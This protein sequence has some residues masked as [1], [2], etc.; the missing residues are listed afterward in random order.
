M[1]ETPQH[2]STFGCW[3]VEK[4]Q[5]RCGAKRISKS[6]WAKRFRFGALLEVQ[7]SKKRTQLW[8]NAHFEVKMLKHHMSAPLSDVQASFLLAGPRGSAR[9]KKWAKHGGFAEVGRL[10]RICTD[11]FR[12]GRSIR[13][14][15]S[16]RW[17]CVTDANFYDLASLFRATRSTLETWDGK[18]IIRCIGTRLSGPHSTFYFWSKSR[19]IASFFPESVWAKRSSNSGG[20]SNIFTSSHLHIFTSS[21]HIFNSHIFSSHLHIFSSSHLLILTSSRLH[22]FSSSHLL[23]FTSSHLH[24]SSSPLLI[25][26]SSHLRIFSSSHP[27]IFT[28]SNR[29]IF[30][31]SHLLT[32]TFSH[33]LVFT[34]SHLRIFSSLHPHIFTSSNRHIFS[35]SH[36]H[37]FTSS[38]FHIF[39]SAH[40][41]IFSFSHPH[42]FTSA[43]LH[44]FSSSH[45]IFTS[46]HLL[47]FTSSQS[48]HLHIFTSSHLHILTS[49]H[50][51]IFTFSLALL[52]SCHL[53]L[54]LLL[55][56]PLALLRSCPLALS[57]FSISLL[58]ARAVPTRRRE[59]Q[60]FRTKRGSIAK[61]WGKIKILKC[62][63]Q[64]FRTKWGS[65]AKNW[66][67]IAIL[68]P[69][70][71]PFRAKW[72]SIAKNTTSAATLSH[73]MRF[74]RQ[75]LR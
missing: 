19:R 49:S 3:D 21:H 5:Q 25:F 4:V 22:I 57:F 23:I 7:M 2:R 74:D 66:G 72:G 8:H 11:A 50:L 34:S 24:I 38:R 70:R 43:H 39:T 26:T 6:K 42:I 28:S 20:L 33:L 64:P 41:H 36:P 12:V 10:K 71:Q 18:I 29:H 52:L 58:K 67:K 63:R 9:C 75:K 60:P 32:F 73:K 1:L 17:F 55:S 16:L 14:S 27:H 30:S 37:I 61:N 68:Q 45:L 15:S 65:I 40:L 62:P 35:F 51:H 31:S 69:P 59:T 54:P 48:S 13:S 47:I 56:C 44:I 53:T 46:S